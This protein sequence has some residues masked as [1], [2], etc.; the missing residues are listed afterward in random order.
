MSQA[1][2]STGTNT[3]WWA[4]YLFLAILITP[5]AQGSPAWY[6]DTTGTF[7]LFDADFLS[8]EDGW[9][10]GIGPNVPPP[11]FIFHWD[12]A[13][14]KLDFQEAF[15]LNYGIDMVSPSDGWVVGEKFNIA[16][17]VMLHYD[18][19]TWTAYPNPTTNILCSVAFSSQDTGWAVGNEV[20]LG[21]E[22]GTWFDATPGFII[23]L[24]NSVRFLSPSLGLAVGCWGRIV[25][26]DGSE[27]MLEASPTSEHLRSVDMVSSNDAWA[28]GD[29]GTIIHYDSDVWMPYASPTL[30]HLRS[31]YM[32]S[33]ADGW[34]VGD[35]GTILHFDG[36]VWEEVW[37]PTTWPL[38]AVCFTSSTEGWAVGGEEVPDGGVI[39][40]YY[41]PV[42]LEEAD[43]GR[44]GIRGEDC[45]SL[46]LSPNPSNSKVTIT[47]ELSRATQ[48]TLCLYDI[49]GK[50]VR[51]LIQGR[52]A[53]GS[54]SAVWDGRGTQGEEVSS[55]LYFCCLETKEHRAVKRILLLR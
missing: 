44:G 25:R 46:K 21:Y 12:G 18:G 2:R 4:W 53:S 43:S 41:D 34:A 52:L 11:G 27:W 47:C 55:G 20:I 54:H 3:M 29:R 17:D 24:L 6:V 22:D 1:G 33:P 26:Y 31:V 40:H 10:C 8:P 15:D 14:W 36:S 35:S 30:R 19:N 38:Y 23:G 42:G 48:A 45:T 5:T 7:V 51:T 16:D 50:K 37:S 13:G 28:V 9:A 32:V 39:L 49:G